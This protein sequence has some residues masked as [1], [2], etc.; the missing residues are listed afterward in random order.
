[1]IPRSSFAFRSIPFRLASRRVH[2]VDR[3]VRPFVD[4]V[5][6]SPTSKIEIGEVPGRLVV[7]GSELEGQVREAG[8]ER[9][10]ELHV[11]RIVACV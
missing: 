8:A 6:S 2:E 11:P 7:I 4:L 10:C 1:M 5:L 9:G 3:S